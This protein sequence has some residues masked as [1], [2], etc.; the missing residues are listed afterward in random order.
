MICHKEWKGSF[1][2]APQRLA[3]AACSPF[4]SCGAIFRLKWECSE[5]SYGCNNICAS[6]ASWS[7]Y[8][9]KHRPCCVCPRI[10]G[11]VTYNLLTLFYGGLF[12]RMMKIIIV[13][14]FKNPMLTITLK[15]L[16]PNFSSY[17]SFL[18]SFSS[19]Y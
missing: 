3:G 5:S 1:L 18:I 19:T 10:H 15:I 6:I 9:D 13:L 2:P 7:M 12:G 16:T 17:S 14:L 4:E 11:T 8:M